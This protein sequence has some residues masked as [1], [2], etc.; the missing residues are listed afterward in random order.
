VPIWK[1]LALLGIKWEEVAR[2]I[3]HLVLG[4][5]ALIVVLAL[6]APV[7]RFIA[8]FAVGGIIAWMLKRA[9]FRDE[10]ALAAFFFTVAAG[11]I[12]MGFGLLEVVPWRP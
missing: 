1:V 11:L 7:I 3:V 4:I 8:L 6:F 12:G 9:G 2:W 10:L 5:I